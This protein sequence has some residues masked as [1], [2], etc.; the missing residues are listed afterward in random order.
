[1]IHLANITD[2]ATENRKAL[3]IICGDSVYNINNERK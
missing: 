1:M 2:K 3:F